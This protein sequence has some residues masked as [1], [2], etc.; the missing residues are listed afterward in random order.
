MLHA[1][2][3]SLFFII[4][5]IYSSKSYIYRQNNPNV[6]SSDIYILMLEREKQASR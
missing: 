3:A 6:A 1:T 4:L 5:F 2:H